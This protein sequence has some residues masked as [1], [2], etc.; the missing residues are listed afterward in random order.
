MS[1]GD[2]ISKS[3]ARCVRSQGFTFLSHLS[4]ATARV[5]LFSE[6]KGVGTNL[7]SLCLCCASV[8]EKPFLFQKLCPL[9]LPDLPQSPTN[10]TARLE[11][12][13]ELCDER[14]GDLG[15]IFHC[16]CLFCFSFRAWAHCCCCCLFCFV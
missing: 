5:I 9:T 2:K 4:P 14:P 11:N 1:K 10:S 13:P 7:W 12:Q 16:C 6:G 3:T 15:S 8:I